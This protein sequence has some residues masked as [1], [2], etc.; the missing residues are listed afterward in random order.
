MFSL[1]T[2]HHKLENGH[3]CFVCKQRK[4]CLLEIITFVCIILFRLIEFNSKK[5]DFGDVLF[6]AFVF[7]EKN[8]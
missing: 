8:N 6:F 4:S 5:C 7:K 3:F 2:T 1:Y